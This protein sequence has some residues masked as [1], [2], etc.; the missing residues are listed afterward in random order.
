MW[1]DADLM[2]N[3]KFN[4]LYRDATN[5]ER[6][7]AVV[8]FN[9][10]HL[11]LDAASHALRDALWRKSFFTAHQVRVP[12]AFQFAKVDVG[13]DDNCFHEFCDLE[14]SEHLPTDVYGRTMS[15]F[16]AEFVREAKGGWRVFELATRTPLLPGENTK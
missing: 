12:E 2:D 4:Y 16:I 11:T 1:E 3:I 7:S 6:G 5:C 14:L 13:S 8:F 15:E 10:H 9:P